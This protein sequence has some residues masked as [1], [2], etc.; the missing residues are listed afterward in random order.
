[1]HKGGFEV[2]KQRKKKEKSRKIEKEIIN[3]G[4]VSLAL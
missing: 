3:Q 4:G 1:M 2:E